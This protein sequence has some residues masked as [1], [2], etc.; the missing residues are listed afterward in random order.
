MFDDQT[1]RSDRA[2]ITGSDL[3]FNVPKLA[4]SRKECAYAIGMSTRKIDE[5]IA[6]RLGSGFPVVYF[7]TKPMVPI[8]PLCKWL[9]EQ[10]KKKGGGR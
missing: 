6:G 2:T 8:D 10:A 1:R 4:L 7:G 3:D 9:A 5:L